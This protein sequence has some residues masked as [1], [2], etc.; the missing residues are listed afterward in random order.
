MDELKLILKTGFARGIIAKI[1]NKAIKKKIGYDVVVNLNE[2]SVK[3]V[4]GK[5]HLHV[6]LNA[7]MY[8]DDLIALAKSKD[9]I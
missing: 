3:M 2:I 4:D 7:E 9:L 6:D 1:I 8:S 5:A